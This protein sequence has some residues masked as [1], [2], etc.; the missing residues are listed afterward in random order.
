[1]CI[2]M[3]SIFSLSMSNSKIP[4]SQSTSRTY[5][6]CARYVYYTVYTVYTFILNW[7]TAAKFT[8][9][10]DPARRSV[11]VYVNVFV[12]ARKSIRFLTRSDVYYII[13]IRVSFRRRVTCIWI[14]NELF[15]EIIF[16]FYQNEF[17]IISW[18]IHNIT[19]RYI[20]LFVYLIL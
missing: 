15:S 16:F 11:C 17:D 14:R 10:I 12:N 6:V 2:I 19:V 20:I 18:N 9:F 1:M 3:Y 5:I 13:I 8:R 4:S 7:K